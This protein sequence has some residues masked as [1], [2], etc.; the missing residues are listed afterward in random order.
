MAFFKKAMVLFLR[1]GISAILLYYLLKDIDAAS[2]F[3][4]A[5]SADK[6]LLVLAFAISLLN[7][8]FCYFR[9]LMLLW[10][11][12]I[13]LP[14]RRVL[15]SFAGGVF[16]NQFL[17]STIGGDLVRSID[18]AVHTKKPKEVVATV[19]L[20]RLSGYM[21]LVLVALAALAVGW[22]LVQDTMV[23]VAVAVIAGVLALILLA[24]FN[25][26]IYS[27]LNA[28]LQAPSGLK[29]TAGF[30]ASAFGKFRES[31]RNLHEEL[32]LFKTR[33]LVMASNLLVSLLIQMVVPVSF[34]IIALS[35]G[36]DISP[37]YFFV[38]LPIISAVTLLPISI[39]GLGLR[40][41]TTVFFFA[42]AGVAKDAAFAMS[43]VSFVFLLIYGILGG[44]IYVFTLHYRRLQPGSPSPLRP[45][46]E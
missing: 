45:E 39:G 22:R 15:I 2:I 35:L 40:D 6:R 28:L 41:T 21:G 46:P 14:K 44:L 43:L 24:V 23:T 9:W 36:V 32:Y 25:K 37:V 27:K 38:F 31:L 13:R 34:Y 16:F 1:F 42:K 7:Y 17:P 12:G 10:A 18:L 11:S 4:V 3:E 29:R 26:F 5:R 30:T 33:K 19:L 8:V 20:D